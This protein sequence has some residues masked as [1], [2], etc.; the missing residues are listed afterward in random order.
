MSFR[1]I[2]ILAIA[3]L[4]AACGAPSQSV[5][6][7]ALQSAAV[8]SGRV[9]PDNRCNYLKMEPFMKTIRVHEQMGITPVLRTGLRVIVNPLGRQ[10]NGITVAAYS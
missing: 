6:P 3:S 5:N 10:P 7:A 8:S 9:S 2:A 1:K 4:A